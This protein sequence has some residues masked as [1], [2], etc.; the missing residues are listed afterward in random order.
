ML[1]IKPL[2]ILEKGHATLRTACHPIAFP[3][4][5][6]PH[7]LS[8]LHATLADFRERKGFGR[9]MAAPQVGIVK[10]IIVM[11]LGAAPFAII[12]PKITWRSEA[13][14]DVWDDCLSVPDC[15]VRVQRHAS[16]SLQYQ[17][18]QGRERHW[19]Q[20]PADLAELV[21][22]EVDHLDGILMTER[23]AGAGSIRPISE[24]AALVASA[25]PQRRLSL[26]QIAHS[27]SVIPPE[28]LNS[29]QYNCEP[30]SEAL[31]CRLTLK[32][33]FTNPIRS[34]KGRGASFFVSEM[35]RRGDKRAIVCASAGN[36][37]QAMAYACRSFGLPI[38]IYASV[39]ANPLKVERMKAL[40]AEVRQEGHD[41]DAA[42][43]A[44]KAYS[45]RI[46]GWMVEDGF[47]PEISEGHGT[48]AIE[49]LARG[50]AFDAIAIPLGNGAMLNGMARWIKAAS[51]ATRVLGVS[52]A[53]ADAMEKSWR[54][55]TI[56]TPD[57][58]DTIA[59]GIAVRVPIPEAVNDMQGLVDDVLLINDAHII[60]A[61][62]L[63]YQHAGL[64]LEPAGAVGIAAIVAHREQF[65]GKTIATVLCGSNITE[66][67]IKEY[68][69]T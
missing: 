17:D 69:S 67:Q 40:G 37:G 21:Q 44:A 20:L 29:P 13:M 14:Q 6:L 49:L 59:D 11:H 10:R 7:Q 62:R 56:I 23:A 3:D 58:A 54:G 52:A 47:D 39:N 63:V 50:D 2:T 33:D 61:M 53:G 30:L 25:R 48:L 24:H 31:G 41:F 19:L 65:F 4:S 9:A 66:S 68:L 43:D 64:M 38:V 60:E 57:A 45:K 32:L 1:A 46:N 42:K 26:A 22:H 51:P 34:F 15:V 27:F 8:Q 36:W 55:Q 28:F 35:Q 5:D 18:E 12:N 16:I